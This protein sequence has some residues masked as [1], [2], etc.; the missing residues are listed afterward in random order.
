MKT[1]WKKLK[2]TYYKAFR[3]IK[4]DPQYKD[5]PEIHLK[6]FAG[7]VAM[8]CHDKI[9][10]PIKLR[11]PYLLKLAELTGGP[12]VREHYCM[13]QAFGRGDA[14]RNMDNQLEL[15]QFTIDERFTKPGDWSYNE[16]Y[17]F[18]LQHVFAAIGKQHKFIS[19][20]ESSI[21]DDPLDLQILNDL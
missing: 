19:L 20:I 8:L 12:T 6:T 21:D 18:C 13:W 15:T 5:K 11:G 4:S 2:S 10:L 16:A 7:C 1:I 3:Q 9:S 14:L 17:D